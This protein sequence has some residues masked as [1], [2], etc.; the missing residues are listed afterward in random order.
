MM[1][2]RTGTTEY[3]EETGLYG[4]YSNIHR[5]NK[6][7]GLYEKWY[8]NGQLALRATYKDGEKWV[9]EEWR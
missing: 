8:D 9:Y 3:N 7:N 1:S 2:E 6:E 5:G 4:E